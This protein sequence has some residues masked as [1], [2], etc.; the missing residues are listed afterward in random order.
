MEEH[1]HDLSKFW[2]APDL[3]GLQLL[4]AT[5]VTHTFPRHFHDT[6]VIGIQES[7]AEK[8]QCLGVPG[9]APAGSIVMLNPGEVHNGRAAEGKPWVY[10][11]FYPDLSLIQEAA[12]EC[13]GARRPLPVFPATVI[14]DRRLSQALSRL[15]RI[16]ETS[17][18]TLERQSC[19]T[20]TMCELITRH[21]DN[22]PAIESTG[23]ESRA[24][25]LTR[26]YITD[27]YQEN[28]SLKELSQVVNLN[29]FYLL[30]A[31]RK[32]MGL[33]P[34]EY[35]TQVRVNRAMELLSAGLPIAEVALETGFV[36]QS[37]L[38]SRFKRIVGVTPKRFAAGSISYK[39]RALIA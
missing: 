18:E 26:D 19:F 16:L 15:H 36:D 30:R 3:N 38:T 2:V 33:P 20:T 14:F 21:A 5:F 12:S 35:L 39:T 24:I 27:H 25:K 32:G 10:R 31:F 37:H 17:Q 34:H 29:P 23:S 11:G 7:G 8:F 4:S 22:R 9:V 28:I 1:K 6:Y 13:H